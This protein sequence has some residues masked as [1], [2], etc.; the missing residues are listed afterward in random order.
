MEIRLL[1]PVE[2]YS[3][4]GPVPIGSA[5]QRALLAFLALHPQRLVT[6]DVLIDGLW[7]DEPPDATVQALRFHV[8]RLRGILRQA[9]D[10]DR[11]RTRPGGY[12]LVIAEDA[13]DVLRFERAIAGARL[14]RSEGAAPDA[15][16]RA[17]RDALDW[18][19][20]PALADINGEPFVVGERRRLDEIRLSATEDYFAAELAAARHAEAVGELE[21]MVDRHPLRERL[22]ELL[23]T[24]LYRSGRQADA[25]AAYQRVRRILADEL[26]I[27]PSTPLRQLEHQVLLQ[28]AGLAAPSTSPRPGSHPSDVPLTAAADAEPPPAQADA[29][30]P[31]GR[32][33]NR[34]AT[35]AIITG[36]V[37]FSASV[38]LLL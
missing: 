16:G 4:R 18:W 15:V 7:G 2:L 36:V 5:K 9:D 11:L 3:A 30:A 8:S 13:V 31:R 38:G 33:T 34:R 22:W 35:V 29:R 12:Q 24:A 1:G 17:F 14:A 26:G 27:E 25:L 19:V 32:A 10:A 23:I 28:D 37:A 20:G 6:Y 21:R